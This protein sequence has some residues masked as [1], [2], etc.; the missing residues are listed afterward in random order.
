MNMR[1][2]VGFLTI[3]QSPRMDV[4]SDMAAILGPEIDILEKGALDG[5]SQN[6]IGRLG[7][8]KNDF[9]LI[10]RLRDGSAVVVGKKKI[11]PRLQSQISSLEKERVQL[12]ALLCTDDFS[13]LRSQKLLLRPY[14][15]LFGAVTSILKKGTLA[16]LAPLAEQKAAVTKKWEK[17]GL[18]I[19]VEDLNPYQKPSVAERV[20]ERIKN[21]NA[22][23]IILDC[24]GYSSRIKEK[25]GRQTRIPVLLPRSVL[26][27][28]IKELV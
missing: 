15:I 28:M 17:T 8:E 7:P 23:L 10:T 21:K 1:P 12:T 5:L 19:I 18:E 4:V 3:G 14:Q 25:I 24:I 13:E 11:I 27:R 6:E 20:I 26:A 16:V 22:N 2:K 9:P